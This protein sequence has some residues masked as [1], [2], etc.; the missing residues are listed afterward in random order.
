MRA[1]GEAAPPE[2]ICDASCSDYDRSPDVMRQ[3][4]EHSK[5][6]F[7][8]NDLAQKLQCT[9]DWTSNKTSET[10]CIDTLGDTAEQEESEEY[11]SKS[12]SSLPGL[13]AFNLARHN[14]R[15]QKHHS[16]FAETSG[17]E[18]TSVIPAAV[19]ELPSSEVSLQVFSVLHTF[20]VAKFISRQ[21]PSYQSVG[22]M[23]ATI[24]YLAT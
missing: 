1:A 19:E 18:A 13:T 10:D 17:F 21:S 14:R 12:D 16:M 15:L 7:R 20:C 11:F 2:R 9:H 8:R 4:S 22:V 6:N 3:Q 24:R 23:A 5:P